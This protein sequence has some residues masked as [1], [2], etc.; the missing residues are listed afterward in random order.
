[1]I[2]GVLEPETDIPVAGMTRFWTGEEPFDDDFLIE[3]A[4]WLKEE[5]KNRNVLAVTEG[6]ADGLRSKSKKHGD[7]DNDP[8]TRAS[9][10]HIVSQMGED[11]AIS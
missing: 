8:E 11:D 2:S 3:T 7:F 1:M 5:G 4:A 6:G 10:I 9:L